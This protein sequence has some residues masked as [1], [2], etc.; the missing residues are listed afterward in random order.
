MAIG[1]VP[2]RPMAKVPHMV[3]CLQG[4][5]V[6]N[7]KASINTRNE[8]CGVLCAEQGSR[9]DRFRHVF[10]GRGFHDG[11]GVFADE[12]QRCVGD[13]F[14]CTTSAARL[15]M[16]CVESVTYRRNVRPQPHTHKD[17]SS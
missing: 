4:L 12:A 15:A 7:E 1:Q 6:V 3:Q 8:A 14:C 9:D 2:K 16:S 5:L 10:D 13:G 11:V 17:A